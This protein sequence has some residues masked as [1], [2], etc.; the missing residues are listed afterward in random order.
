MIVINSILLQRYSA[1]EFIILELINSIYNDLKT[2]ENPHPLLTLQQ[3]YIQL[4]TRFSPNVVAKA[5]KKLLD[6]NIILIESE[7][8]GACTLYR[9]NPQVVRYWI[10][11]CKEKQCPLITGRKIIKSTGEKRTP[12]NTPAPEIYRY[13]IGKSIAKV[14]DIKAKQAEKRAEKKRKMSAHWR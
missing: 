11:Q 4:Y 10:N 5:I 2:R 1:N 3:N 12:T 8:R 6:D 14:K 7:K 9:Y 13:M